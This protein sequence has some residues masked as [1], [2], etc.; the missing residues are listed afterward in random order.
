MSQE[1]LELLKVSKNNPVKRK[2]L[3]ENDEIFLKIIEIVELNCEKD[4]KN[5]ENIEMNSEE[6]LREIKAI[7]IRK[8][9]FARL[10]SVKYDKPE[11]K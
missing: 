1:I 7:N 3:L 5:E 4:I 8:E 11:Q 9:L 6:I 10:K 2:E